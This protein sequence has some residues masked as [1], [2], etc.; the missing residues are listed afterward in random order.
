MQITMKLWSKLHIFKASFLHDSL[1]YSFL[2]GGS[3]AGTLRS[4]KALSGW[5]VPDFKA[6]S[7][8]GLIALRPLWMLSWWIIFLICQHLWRTV[9]N[10]KNSVSGLLLVAGCLDFT[11]DNRRL[12]T[13]VIYLHL[14][15]FCLYIKKTTQKSL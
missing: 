13:N 1:M 8:P 12:T 5:I 9:S 4:L 7:L 6:H 14:T 15:Q 10:L 3:E 11:T 2:F